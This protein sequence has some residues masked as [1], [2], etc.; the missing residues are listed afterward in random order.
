MI[1]KTIKTAPEPGHPSND[2]VTG[3]ETPTDQLFTDYEMDAPDLRTNPEK[4]DILSEIDEMIH[5]AMKISEEKPATSPVIEDLAGEISRADG[6]SLDFASGPIEKPR[7]GRG[8]PPKGGHPLDSP[9]ISAKLKSIDQEQ[10]KVAVSFVNGAMLLLVV[11][12]IIPVAISF[13]VKQTMKK[14]IK[15]NDIKLDDDEKKELQDIAD[16]VASRI[17]AK[18]SPETIFLI[19]LAGIYGAKTISVIQE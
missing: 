5:Q 15:R 14:T 8:R 13:A 7:R 4:V 3:G 9:K 18:A 6:I 16:M 17:S 2:L 12:F 10:E 11:D 19:A 1:K